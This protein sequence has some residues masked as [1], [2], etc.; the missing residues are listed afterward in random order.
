MPSS[1]AAKNWAKLAILGVIWGASFMF[2]SV[3]LQTVGPLMIVAARI[4]LGAVFLLGLAYSIGNGLPPI[5]GRNGRIIWAFALAMGV[6]SNAV[7]FALLTW[8]Q[9]FVASGFAGVCMSVVPL[10]VLPL[11]HF[12]VPGDRMS[13][14]RLVGFVIGTIGVA[15]LIGPQAFA[16][17][18]NSLEMFA[19]LACVGAAG[20]YAV[21]SICTRLCP[22]VDRLGLAAATL[23]LAA[24]IFTPYALL[25]EVLPGDVSGLSLIA[26]LYLG[27]LPTGVA[28]ILLVQ[29]IR[30]AGPVF[31][32][33]VNYQVPIWSVVFGVLL[34][35]EPLPPSLI[36]AMA[37][38]LGGV[39]LSQ[40]GALRRLFRR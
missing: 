20:C 22:D 28:Q 19:R 2:V 7:P 11:A 23:L 32:S 12:A 29:V 6:F 18:G 4:S 3:A 34:L 38:I 35:A 31:M 17:T 24:V 9:Q 14:R 15:V 30:D 36:T 21:G 5:K 16:S 25:N 27:I 8:G 1:I 40:L 33:L 10:L 13:L 39:M 26:L 37:L